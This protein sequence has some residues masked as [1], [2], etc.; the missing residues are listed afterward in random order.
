MIPCA[1]VHTHFNLYCLG[2]NS[3][4]LGQVVQCIYL[5]VICVTYLSCITDMYPRTYEVMQYHHLPF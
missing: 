4:L 1:D 5:N 2:L 3:H